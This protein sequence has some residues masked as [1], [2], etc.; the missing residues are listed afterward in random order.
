MD[1]FYVDFLPLV[2]AVHIF[3]AVI[4]VGGMIFFIFNVYPS[5]LQIPNEKM[6][7][8]TSIRTLMRFFRF[9]MP[10]TLLLGVSG[11]LMADGKD[12]THRDPVMSVIVT[13]K[14][15]IWL[16]MFM[17][18]I[19]AFYK[20]KE[21]KQK[22]LASDSEHAKDNI[23]LISYYLFGMSSLLGLCAIYFG[24]ILRGV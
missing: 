14:E 6:F 19:F 11:F 23:K 24:F 13:S 18:Y 10:V 20:V 12:F 9:L 7:V 17:L 3:C 2:F 22:C 21:A 1:K 4:W 16:F 15:F 5:N 8:R